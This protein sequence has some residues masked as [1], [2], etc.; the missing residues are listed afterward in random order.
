M[1]ATPLLSAL[2]PNVVL[3]SWQVT[4]PV[5]PAGVTTA[6]RV[7]G[8]PEVPGLGEAVSAVV[9]LP[10]A[11]VSVAVPVLVPNLL[12]PLYTAESEWMPGERVA[13]LKVAPPLLS[14]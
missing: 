2:L 1:V 6:R 3:P 5:A 11:T 4:V 9:V 13:V 8:W 10:L 7:T 14:G 12:S